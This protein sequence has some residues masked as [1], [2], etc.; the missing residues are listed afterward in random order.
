MQ[1]CHDFF[2]PIRIK[3]KVYVSTIWDE[4]EKNDLINIKI[5]PALAFGTGH[6]ETTYMMIQAILQFL[7]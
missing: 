5:N 2:K 6:H 7:M 1:N 4:D 3:D